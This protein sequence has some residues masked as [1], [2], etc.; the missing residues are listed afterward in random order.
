[1]QDIIRTGQ[2]QYKS[3]E[4]DIIIKLEQFWKLL[5]LNFQSA[6]SITP[7]DKRNYDRI[8]SILSYIEENYSSKLTLE[9]IAEHIHLCKGECCRLF[10]QY[11]KIPLFEFIIEFRIE[12]SLNYLANSNFSISDI[13]VNVGFNDSNYYSKTF[14]KIKGC[15]ILNTKKS[16]LVRM[17][18][19][20]NL[21]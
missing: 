21:K 7:Y 8:R 17:I 12:K 11:M 6:P 1:M 3:Y 9:D 2:Q 14:C 20:N 4:I 18:Y 16:F 13:A 10:K 19:F 5:F 15:S